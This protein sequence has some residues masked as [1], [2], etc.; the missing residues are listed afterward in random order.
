MTGLDSS[1]LI[2]ALA[3]KETRLYCSEVTK[4]LL[5]YDTNFAKLVPYLV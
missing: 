4:G 1:D 3:S 5:S 2:F